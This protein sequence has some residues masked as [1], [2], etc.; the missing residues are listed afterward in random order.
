MSSGAQFPKQW[1][2]SHLILQQYWHSN[3]DKVKHGGDSVIVL[4]DFA[5]NTEKPPKQKLKKQANKHT[6]KQTK[7]I[8]VNS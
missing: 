2:A 6:N 3:P 7:T 4:E 1:S 5:T 8:N